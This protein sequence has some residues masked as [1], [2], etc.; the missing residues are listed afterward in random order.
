MTSIT[1]DSVESLGWT[2]VGIADDTLA[3]SHRQLWLLTRPQLSHCGPVCMYMNIFTLTH[4]HISSALWSHRKLLMLA[5]LRYQ[6]N[7]TVPTSALPNLTITEHTN[8]IRTC[9]C[10]HRACRSIVYGTTAGETVR[11]RRERLA[12]PSV[13]SVV[14]MCVVSPLSHDYV[15]HCRDICR[16]PCRDISCAQRSCTLH[17]HAYIHTYI[18]WPVAEHTDTRVNQTVY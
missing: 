8:N 5:A 2:T 11:K 6:H 14:C 10:L 7:A 4:T 18:Q 12:E 13:D 1:V 9:Q 16:A 17:A 3:S 15:W